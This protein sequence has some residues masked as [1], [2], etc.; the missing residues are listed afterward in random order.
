MLPHDVLGGTPLPSCPY[1]S[2]TLSF[3]PLASPNVALPH[4]IAGTLCVALAIAVKTRYDGARVF[5]RT[6]ADSSVRN[7]RWAAYFALVGLSFL[8]DFARY[9]LDLPHRVANTPTLKP[10]PTPPDASAAVGVSPGST[11]KETTVEPHVID[12]WLLI[13][14]AVL[15]SCAVCLLALALN[16]QLLYRSNAILR[17]R[18]TPAD[19]TRRRRADST[20]SST[21]SSHRRPSSYPHTY[22]TPSSSPIQPRR[23]SDES[24]CPAAD[25]E[26][27]PPPTPRVIAATRPF[28]TRRNVPDEEQGLLDAHRN[29]ATVAP[30]LGDDDDGDSDDDG[31]CVGTSR[32][33]RWWCS[34]GGRMVAGWGMLSFALLILNLVALYL[35]VNPPHI[36]AD[37]TSLFLYLSTAFSLIQRLPPYILTIYILTEKYKLAPALPFITPS[38]SSR[39]PRTSTSSHHPDGPTFSTK[40]VALIAA[41]LALPAL[42]E[43]SVLARAVAAVAAKYSSGGVNDEWDVDRVCVVPPWWWV[44]VGSGGNDDV[45]TG[46]HGWASV[47][48]LCVWSGV[49]AQVAWFGFVRREWRRNKEEWVWLT[50]TELQSIFDFRRY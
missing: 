26:H 6:V 20:T 13:T 21:S 41:V 38:S 31:W 33:T 39:H 8:I 19:S 45:A 32:A 7:G 24:E 3:L 1:P 5:N 27:P 15:R 36:S 28:S 37:P 4:L 11:R 2:S 43:P 29:P 10:M 50:V 42:L 40:L 16:H 34:C 47:V 9:A 22:S 48:D 18:P 44:D 14:S 30:D 23:R 12:A 49:A 46:L 17:D 25:V 35:D